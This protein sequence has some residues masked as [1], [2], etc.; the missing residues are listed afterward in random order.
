MELYHR[1]VSVAVGCYVAPGKTFAGWKEDAYTGSSSPSRKKSQNAEAATA[2]MASLS[3]SADAVRDARI[4]SNMCTVM[5]S[6]MR[7]GEA[8]SILVL[9]IPTCICFNTGR[10]VCSL[11]SGSLR[12]ICMLHN[13]ER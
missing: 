7:G 10:E 4:Y 6:L 9:L 8:F 1:G 5:G 12:E 2:Q 13:A 3:G 11:G